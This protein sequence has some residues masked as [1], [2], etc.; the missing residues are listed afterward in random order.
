LAPEGGAATVELHLTDASDS[1][2]RIARA[3]LG[4]NAPQPE[5]VTLGA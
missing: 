1:F 4:D 2:L 5:V 3:I